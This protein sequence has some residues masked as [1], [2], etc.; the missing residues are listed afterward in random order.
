M[1]SSQAS[2][3]FPGCPPGPCTPT[4]PPSDPK[5]ELHVPHSTFTRARLPPPTSGH[6]NQVANCFYSKGVRGRFFSRNLARPAPGR[7]EGVWVGRTRRSEGRG[8]LCL[9]LGGRSWLPE[10]RSGAGDRFH[11]VDKGSDQTW[12]LQKRQG[13]GDPEI[14]FGS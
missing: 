7:A 1:T 9:L 11:A 14:G 13:R 5:L 12:G 4:P 2:H 3:T 8:P 10:L 6:Q